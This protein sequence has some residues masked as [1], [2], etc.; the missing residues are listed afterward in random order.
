MSE[1][2]CKPKRQDKNNIVQTEASEKN[3]VVQT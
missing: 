2:S 1:T 3:N